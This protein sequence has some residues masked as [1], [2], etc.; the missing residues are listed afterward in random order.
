M[1]LVSIS[2]E[3]RNEFGKASATISAATFHRRKHCCVRNLYGENRQV[4]ATSAGHLL[5]K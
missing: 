5:R 2:L 3:V 4:C 1:T